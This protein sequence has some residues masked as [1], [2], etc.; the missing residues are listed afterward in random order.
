[1]K[2]PKKSSLKKHPPLQSDKR[3][4]SF[5]DST[6]SPCNS[7]GGAF[8]GPAQL[9]QIILESIPKGTFLLTCQDL[10][11]A[12]G[13]S[14]EHRQSLLQ[15]LVRLHNEG[16][17]DFLKEVGRF[18]STTGK[19]S[20]PHFGLWISHFSPLFSK[21]DCP[22][23]SIC[24]LFAS[25]DTR[26]AK[27][28]GN[29]IW[30]EYLLD[31]FQ[32]DVDSRRE[33]LRLAELQDAFCPGLL[34]AF[35]AGL[36]VEPG[37]T[38]N[39]MLDL[40][41]SPGKRSKCF[42]NVMLFALSG[43]DWKTLDSQS[44]VAFWKII[45]AIVA[46]KDPPFDWHPLYLLCHRLRLSGLGGT[47][48][49]D[50]LQRVLSLNDPVVLAMAAIN[51]AVDWTGTDASERQ[52]SLEAFSEITPDNRS[53]LQN[54]DGFLEMIVRD[55]FVDTA[56]GFLT[57]YLVRWN[58]SLSV[59]SHFVESMQ[60][61]VW[62]LGNT[63]TC[64]FLSGNQVL[65]RAAGDLIPFEIGDD[66]I[67]TIDIG[68]IRNA[69]KSLLPVAAKMIGHLFYKP[70][71]MFS[72]LFP[73]LD[74]M[75]DKEKQNLTPVLLDPV[76][77][78]YHEGIRKWMESDKCH[79][80]ETSRTFLGEILKRAEADTARLS[81]AG[82]CPELR[83]PLQLQVE[84]MRVQEDENRESMKEARSN[85]LLSVLAHNIDLLHGKEWILYRPGGDGPLGRSVSELKQHSISIAFPRLPDAVGQEFNYRLVALKMGQWDINTLMEFVE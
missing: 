41:A 85:S 70:K 72:F 45:A 65:E 19:Q 61:Y 42:F 4:P 55:G 53:L 66:P 38:F 12:A 22:L 79:L 64:W 63:A 26:W 40:L 34:R 3:S 10:S 73:C 36:S 46:G 9:E 13:Q 52:W 25:F 83:P 6:P 57:S 69:Q 47:S 29:G 78:S 80:E 15:M 32:R 76:C 1:M 27:D 48:C 50:I 35:A 37:Q 67:P 74:Y 16:K 49:G 84:L 20:L 17:I 5:K 58:V 7:D 59:F 24:T 18:C 68:Q 62:P 31:R 60:C 44:Q 77:L 2:S 23:E 54:L 8:P 51:L 21:V 14:V 39:Q 82:P 56:T 81:K 30:W 33:M 28:T 75:D 43:A 71:T 11:F